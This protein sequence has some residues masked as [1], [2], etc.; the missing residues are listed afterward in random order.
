[1]N[2]KTALDELNMEFAVPVVINKL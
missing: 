2:V 1:M